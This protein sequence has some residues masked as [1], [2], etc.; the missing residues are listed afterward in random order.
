MRAN[1]SI[2]SE[3]AYQVRILFLILTYYRYSIILR[4]VFP[5][6][7]LNGKIALLCYDTFD[8]TGYVFFVVVGKHVD[9]Y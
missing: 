3:D 5:N 8:G 6:D 1:I 4:A 7:Q 9:A 2:R